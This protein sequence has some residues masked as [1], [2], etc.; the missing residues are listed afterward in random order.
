MKSK[1]LFVVGI[2]DGY[3]MK[4][5]PTIKRVDTKARKRAI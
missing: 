5:V 4:R 2:I 3:E 1:T